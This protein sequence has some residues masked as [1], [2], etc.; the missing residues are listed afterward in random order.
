MSGRL[1][2]GYN[3]NGFAHHRLGDALA[4][5][6]RLGYDGVALTLDWHHLDPTRVSR[7]ELAEVRAAVAGAGLAVVVETG[8]RFVLDPWRKHEPTL[9]SPAGRERRL[10]F[11]RRAVD[12][13][14]AL[15]AEAVSF[16]SGRLLAAVDRR[17]AEEWLLEGCRTLAAHA[18]AAGVA[19][20][21][22]PEPG[23]LVDTLE[24]AMRVR[25]AVGSP[26]LGLTLDVGHVR[27]TEAVSEAE[28]IERYAPWIRTVH[29]EDIA[30]R[31]HNHLMFGE[32]DLAFEPILGALSRVGFAGLVSVEL[33]RDSHRAPEVAADALAFLRARLGE[34]A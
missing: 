23:M 3:T 16:F 1:R 21:L 29:I 31:E 25:E 4:I 12:V 26:A 32:G 24:R 9:V 15:D 30:G 19:L 5:L 7:D 6:S 34:P 8:A 18:G 14:R 20:G 10:D 27:C 33:S 17:Q 28:A 13:A 2:F 22:E 11:L